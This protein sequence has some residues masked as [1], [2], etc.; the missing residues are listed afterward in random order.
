MVNNINLFIQVTHISV[1]IA[2]CKYRIIKQEFQTFKYFVH[3]INFFFFTILFTI[4]SL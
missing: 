2:F 1:V 4:I 3:V